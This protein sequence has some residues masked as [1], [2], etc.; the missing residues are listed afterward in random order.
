MRAKR[1][2]LLNHQ[3]YFVLFDA[4]DF[5]QS[6]RIEIEKMIGKGNL[7]KNL[8]YHLHTLDLVF[9]YHKTHLSSRGFNFTGI[10]R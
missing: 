10:E 1:N 6:L 3:V 9:T 8:F 5:S 2:L 4:I 7:T